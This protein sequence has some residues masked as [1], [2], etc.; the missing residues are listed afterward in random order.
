MLVTVFSSSWGHGGASLPG[1][2]GLTI[3]GA[4]GPGWSVTGCC[5]C[6]GWVARGREAGY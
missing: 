2:M 5:C 6:W 3:G 1:A 4:D